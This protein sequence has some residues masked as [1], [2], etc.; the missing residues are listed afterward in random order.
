MRPEADRIV[1]AL[2]RI[3]D[4][5][6]KTPAQVAVAWVLAQPGISAAMIGP[7]APEHVDE[8]LGGEGWNLTAEDL[9]QLDE[10]S[11]WSVNLGQIT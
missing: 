5:H 6:G 8:N 3:G 4:A 10:L 11:Q 2:I 9:Q 7:D 1:G